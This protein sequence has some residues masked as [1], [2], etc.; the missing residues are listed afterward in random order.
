[1]TIAK[2]KNSNHKQRKL[3]WI[4][5]ILILLIVTT[6]S[7]DQIGSYQ[8]F[9]QNVLGPLANRYDQIVAAHKDDGALET[10]LHRINLIDTIAHLL[11]ESFESTRSDSLDSLLGDIAD[12]PDAHRTSSPTH[13]IEAREILSEYTSHFG[14]TI[15]FSSLTKEEIT[16]LRNYYD[17]LAKMAGKFIAQRGKM[18]SAINKQSGVDVLE[19]CMVM[20]FLHLS[21]QQWAA[22]NI[23]ALPEWMKTEENI[24][25]LERFSLQVRRPITAY[26]FSLFNKKSGANNKAR[27][28][29]YPD[30]LLAAAESLIKHS[31]YH[32][33]IHCIRIGIEQAEQAKKQETAVKL[34]FRLGDLLSNMGHPDLAAKEM[35]QLMELYP[36]CS[37]WG[38]AA[39]LRVIYLYKVG[40]FKTV[41]SEADKYKSDRRCNDYLAQI[42]YVS[43]VT[44]HKRLN[45][46]ETAQKL[47]QQFLKQYSE[48]PLGADMYLTSAMTAMASGDYEE[49]DRLLEI[50]EYNY[51]KSRIQ[52]KAKNLREQLKKIA[53]GKPNG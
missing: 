33:A 47:Q 9:K 48:H 46:L 13:T 24:S 23:K 32:V 25:A 7:A 52:Q 5:N 22:E 12:A 35:L 20:P 38:K 45:D 43:W 26:Q 41:A 2:Q 10:F 42:L 1:M 29:T 51:P 11:V 6:C 40:D 19:L 16:F 53:G 36:K 4:T 15:S 39:L 31:D 50:V 3:L 21:D 30:Y 8:N 17:T 49:A 27:E 44:H 14:E 37:D 18:V 28:L 34:H